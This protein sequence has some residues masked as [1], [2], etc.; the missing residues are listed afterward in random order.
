MATL[1]FQLPAAL[2]FYRAASSLSSLHHSALLPKDPLILPN[3]IPLLGLYT[4]LL[5]STPAV[6]EPVILPLEGMSILCLVI[7]NLCP[8]AMFPVISARLRGI[9]LFCVSDCVPLALAPWEPLPAVYH[10]ICCLPSQNPIFACLCSKPQCPFCSSP[11]R[12][13]HFA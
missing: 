5:P 7:T 2:A 4:T 13:K 8:F 9:L 6:L 3:T 12:P 1:L 10:L 11:T